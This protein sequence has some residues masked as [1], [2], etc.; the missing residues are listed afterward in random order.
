[1]RLYLVSDKVDPVI[2]MRLAGVE[3]VCLREPE[4][5]AEAL[6]TAA[7]TADI[8]VLLYTAGV[9]ESCPE[10]VARLQRQN[11]PLLLEIPDGESASGNSGS[12][13]EYIQEAVGIHL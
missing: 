7:G 10:T 4:R 11:R 13:T 2:G 1:M 6:E 12:I 9:R 8:G 3:G 5:L